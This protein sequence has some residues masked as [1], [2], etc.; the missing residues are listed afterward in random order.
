M[1]YA[2]GCETRSPRIE[3]KPKVS[4]KP[5]PERVIPKR[6]AKMTR[7][8]RMVYLVELVAIKYGLT[9]HDII[10]SKSRRSLV[11]TAK[12]EAAYR[13]RR[14]MPYIS[15]PQ[16]GKFFHTDH[17][18]AID[19]CAK[20]HLMS[21]KPSIC[22]LVHYLN[23]RARNRDHAREYFRNRAADPSFRQHHNA[24]TVAAYR[25]KVLSR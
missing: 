10:S 12:C 23:R 16:L 13:I 11:M 18:T 5:K 24:R 3:P 20:F 2:K 4:P 8:D 14:T 17:S 21:G 19:R 22:S 9:A 6:H 7:R 15:F 25:E 1:F